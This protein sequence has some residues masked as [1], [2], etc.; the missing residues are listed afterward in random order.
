[1]KNCAKFFQVMNYLRKIRLKI[2]E[3]WNRGMRLIMMIEE[4]KMPKAL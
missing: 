4:L 1:M 3:R 2:I